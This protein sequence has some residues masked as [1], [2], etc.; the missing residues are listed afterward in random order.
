MRREI[1]L[2][3]VL[4]LILLIGVFMY[5]EQN[6]YVF[7][8]EVRANDIKTKLDEVIINNR[9]IT[10]NIINNNNLRNVLK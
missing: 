9:L 5:L 2:N 10:E 4:S 1:F 8:R 3:L 7:T 6:M